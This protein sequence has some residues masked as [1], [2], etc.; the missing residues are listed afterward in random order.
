MGWFKHEAI[1]IAH[2]ALER[3]VIENAVKGINS[4]CR[5]VEDEIC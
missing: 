2:C 5:E 4:A 1:M 3:R